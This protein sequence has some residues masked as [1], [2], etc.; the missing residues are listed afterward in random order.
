V[1]IRRSAPRTLSLPRRSLY[2]PPTVSRRTVLRGAAGAGALSAVGG[3]AACGGDDSGGESGSAEVTLGSNRGDEV[4]NAAE[5]AMMDA[6]AEES[7]FEITRNIQDNETF[8]ESINNYLQG[9]PDDVFT[10]FAGFRARFFDDQGFIGD[11]S[12]V[13]E[14]IGDGYSDAFRAASS[15]GDKQIFVPMYNYPWAVFYRKSVFEENGWTA[16]ET[17]EDFEA[18]AQEIQGAGLVPVALGN[19][20]GWPSMGTFDILNMRM[21]G[22]D[23]HVALMAGEEDW[24]TPEVGAVFEQWAALLP[25]HQEDP[26]GRTWQEAAQALQTREA[27]MYFLGM[28]VGEQFAEGDDE[29]G[30]LDFFAFPEIDSSIGAGDIDAPID[31]YMLTASPENEEGA[32]EW[33]RFVGSAAAQDIYVATSPNVIAAHADAD[34]SRYTDLQNK[35]VE[36]IGNATGIAQFLDRDTRPDF[37]STVVIPT[38]QAFLNN[39]ADIE[40]VLSDL[41]AGK[42]R[43]FVEGGSTR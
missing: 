22:Y 39:P 26:N 14:D 3:L 23:F 12:D 18:L 32:K 31:G 19:Q 15:N 25:Y 43:L 34:T 10:W 27:A 33:L 37:A 35:A 7:D 6:F 13:W 40:T 4:P 1:P 2:L 36:L 17:L 8:Q 16:P 29:R 21:N 42:E 38:F 5:Q 11:V 20:D 41:Q 30:D 28:F 9:D 24:D